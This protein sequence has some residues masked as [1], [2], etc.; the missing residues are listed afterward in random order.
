MHRAIFFVAP[1]LAAGAA[2]AR[3]DLYNNGPFITAAGIGA[4]GASVCQLQTHLG[5]SS[6]GFL[7]QRIPANSRLADDFTVPAGGWTLSSVVFYSFQSNAGTPV[8]TFTDLNLRIWSG[9]PGLAG[10]T[11]I[12]GDTV[13]NRLANSIWTGTYRVP[14]ETPASVQRPIY[15][16]VAVIDPPLELAPGVYW[17]DWQE[18]GTLSSGPWA[19]P[20]T[21]LG[22]TGPAG[23]NSIYL[24]PPNTNWLVTRDSSTM[25][26]QEMTFIIRGTAGSGGGPACYA[27]CDQSTA[28]PFL[29]I[30]DFI[31]FQQRFAAG[32]SRA[33]CDASSQVPT[34]N[35]N[36]FICFQQRFA[37]GC[38]AP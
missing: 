21:F 23:A 38:S 25:A 11:V 28:I 8:S 13:T 14:F 17:L 27:N 2:S 37:A 12:W 15:E 30:N 35:I 10:S 4:G 18:S 19:V 22:Q 5:M 3:P 34:L 29:N 20:V 24:L 6:Y 26:A 33:N 1:C 36:D 31:C 9:R 32:D 7:H 16:N